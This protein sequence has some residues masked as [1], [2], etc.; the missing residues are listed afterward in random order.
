MKIQNAS[1]VKVQC[2]RLETDRGMSFKEAMVELEKAKADGREVGFFQMKK[3]T[4]GIKV[5]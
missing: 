3:F 4:K 1:V 2:H 5:R